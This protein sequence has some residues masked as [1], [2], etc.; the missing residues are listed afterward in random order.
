MYIPFAI[1]LQRIE[2]ENNAV[3]ASVHD[4][5]ISQTPLFDPVL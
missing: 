3:A 5:T 1:S 4:A 2:I